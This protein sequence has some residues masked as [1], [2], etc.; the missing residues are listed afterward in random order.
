M[1]LAPLHAVGGLSIQIIQ[2]FWL[3]SQLIIQQT[4]KCEEPNEIDTPQLKEWYK[5]SDV[6]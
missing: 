4:S 5:V 6:I 2:M 3:H 1:H